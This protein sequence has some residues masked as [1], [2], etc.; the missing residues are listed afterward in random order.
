MVCGRSKF[1]CRIAAASGRA[2]SAAP[3]GDRSGPVIRFSTSSRDTDCSELR[4]KMIAMAVEGMNRPRRNESPGGLRRLAAL[5]CVSELAYL[6]VVSRSQSLHETGTGGA[7]L[8]TLLA[9]FAA[10][11]GI[12]LYG[13][14]VACRAPQDRRLVRLIVSAAVVFR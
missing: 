8:L 2:R 9:L 14:G 10:T 3:C 12:Y 11:T 6:A 5:A 13:I 7:S 4:E 1:P